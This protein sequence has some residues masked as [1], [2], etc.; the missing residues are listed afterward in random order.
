MGILEELGKCFLPSHE[1]FIFMWA[2]FLLGVTAVALTIERWIEIN[3]RTDYDASSLFERIKD[4]LQQ[5]RINEIEQICLSSGKRAL[6][7][8]L[9]AGI[10]KAGAE[11]VIV[12]GAMTEESVHMCSRMEKRLNLLIMF[13]NVSTLLGLLGTVF[14][15]IMAFAAVGKSGVPPTEKSALLA[16]GISTAMNSTLVGLTISIPCLMA[17]ALLRSKVDAALQE[18]DRYAIALLKFLNP[19]TTHRERKLMSIGRNRGSEDIADTDVTPMLNLMVML[20]PFL[21]TSSEFVKIGA[22]EMKLPESTKNTASATQAPTEETQGVKLNL[23]IVITS[24]GFN[25]IDYFKEKKADSSVGDTAPDIPLV[26]GDYDYSALNERLADIKKKVLYEILRPY[27]ADI[28]E[29]SSL[30]ELYHAYV[31]LQPFSVS[32]FSDHENVK[33]V[34]EEQ[35]KYKTVVAVMDASRGFRTPEGNVTMFPNVA[36]AGGIVQ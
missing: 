2:L 8:I 3:R 20:I 32:E 14:G 36:I 10:R 23:G 9:G 24:K 19:P 28:T 13:G 7:R 30:S 11:L 34:A 27:V 21:L 22:I 33:I 25:V 18:I 6:P 16:S 29:G 1:A 12:Q 5:Q 35:I 26:D 31:K 15:L 4:L 17:Y